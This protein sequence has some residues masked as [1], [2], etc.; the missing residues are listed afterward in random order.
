VDSSVKAFGVSIGYR[1]RVDLDFMEELTGFDR[2]RIINDLQGVIFLEKDDSREWYVPAD[3]YLSGNVRKKLEIAKAYAEADPRFEI[4]VSALEKAQPKDL[5]AHEIYVRLGTTWIDRK[6]IQ[7]FMYEILE[8]PNANK[9]LLA[10]GAKPT[11]YVNAKSDERERITVQYS[12]VSNEWR[13]TNKN[14]I[15]GENIKADI[16]FGTE[17]INAYHIMELT[18][19]LKEVVIKKTIQNR[20]G[21]D[22]E[23]V[24]E[25]ETALARQKQEDLKRIFK[26][27][28][29]K[30][31][32]RREGL[33]ST[34]NEKFNAIRPREY[35]GKHIVF[36]GM[37]AEIELEEHQINGVARVMYGGNTLLAHEVGAGKSFEMIAAAMESK[38]IG[39]CTKSL[40][41]VP[42]HLTG[43]MASEFLR[44]Y[45]NANILVA[46]DKTFEPKNRK[47]F[48]SK[49]V[50]GNYDAV[51]MGH[52]QF[53]MLP[54]SKE[55][56]EKYYTEQF[57]LLVDAI[58]EAKSADSGYFTVKQMENTKNKVK[59]KLDNLYKDNRKD[60]VIT[61]EQMGIDKLF[62]DEAHS[63]KNLHLYT[64]MR[65]VAGISQTEAQKS[66]DMFMKCRYLDEE[67]GNKGVT[68]AT[69]T[70]E[71][72]HYL[73]RQK[74]I[75]R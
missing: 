73:Y 67:T 41:A 52:T 7:Q 38:R 54:L 56:Q 72:T 48:C 49:I 32:E 65:N 43:Q 16:E 40:I 64:K 21:K 18:L 11:K 70:P 50:T 34:F 8:T 59:A 62:V 10:D 60:D 75:I 26:D 25:E 74:P 69:G 57:H 17:K 15:D 45:P 44:L 51:I 47:R 31:P 14:S 27:W 63:F 46:T 13:I 3:E 4:N 28:I 36:A 20:E 33:V 55:N 35:D 30:D 37:N 66:A 24:D 68:F 22:V 9:A 5:E 53:E 1:G 23:V 42:K 6:Y 39:Q 12:P 19:N 71:Y 2:E 29:F 58:N 61:F